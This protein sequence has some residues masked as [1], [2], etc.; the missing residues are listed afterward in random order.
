M[1]DSWYY[2]ESSDRSHGPM[3][4]DELGRVL[5]STA[6]ATNFLVWRPGM[7]AWARAADQPALSRYFSPP[8]LHPPNA[9][10]VP[11]RLNFADAA[12]RAAGEVHPWRRYFARMLDL[13]VFYLVFFVFLGI[14]F[15]ALFAD[16]ADKP[17][18]DILYTILGM[19][20]Y[21]VFE[22]FCLNIFGTSLGKKLYGIRLQRD[23]SEGFT[24]SVTFRR[25][26]LVWMRGLGFGIPLASLFTLIIAYN[27]LSSQGR[28]TWDR[29]CRCSVTH[30]ELSALRWT[31]IIVIWIAMIAIYALILAMDK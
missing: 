22:G 20:A 13:Y 10:P 2:A 21:V 14:A 5:G 26:F 29:D 8:P 27:T 25:S 9:D 7:T 3:T 17:G 30:S 12:G 16:T 15:P 24:L 28:T 18:V 11:E 23:D 4:V 31:S 6:N 1:E 19:L